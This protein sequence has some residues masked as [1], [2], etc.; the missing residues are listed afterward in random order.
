MFFLNFDFPVDY[1]WRP[2]TVSR[3]VTHGSA[4]VPHCSHTFIF[5][6]AQVRF[7][8][9]VYHCNISP[10]SGMVYLD[11]LRDQWSPALGVEK[12]LNSI[13]WLLANPAPGASFT[14]TLCLCQR[15]SASEVIADS[16]P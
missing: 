13:Q 12:V 1:P 7:I 16:A 8:T 9:K 14:V 5:S 15:L 3:P 10:S 2:P 4:S 6:F 11:I